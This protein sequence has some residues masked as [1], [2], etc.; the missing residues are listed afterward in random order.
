VKL[1][2]LRRPARARLPAHRRASL[3]VASA[4]T[5]LAFVRCSAT[6]PDDSAPEVQVLLERGQREVRL[7]VDGAYVVVDRDGET[8]AGGRRLVDGRLRAGA[9]G[10]ELNGVELDADALVLRSTGGEPFRVGGH[11]Y[12]GELEVRRTQD[13]ALELVDL[14]DIEEYV[15]G[16]LFSEMPANFPDAALQAQAVAARSYARWRLNHG[17]PLLRATDADQVYGGAGPLHAR[18]RA[19]VAST[20]GLVLESDGAPLPAYFMSTCGGAT[21]D[22]PLVFADAPRR[23]LIGARCD[24]CTASP[25]YRWARS[26]ALPELERRLGLAAGSTTAIH[27]RRDAFGHSLA[28]EMVAAGRRRRF[29]GLEFRRLWNAGASSDAEKLPSAWLLSLELTKSSLAVQGAGFGHGVGL[30]QYGAAGLASRGLD[31]REILERYYVGARLVK[32]W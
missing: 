28:F 2:E 5:A 22:G 7:G 6:S 11:R 30:C 1:D 3:L 21:V 24:G 32:R 31:W 9:S 18:A 29:D 10:F 16:V 20:R 15:A 13:G 12:S 17:D 26:L 23:G 19:I 14:L 25:K 4:A 8:L 27:A